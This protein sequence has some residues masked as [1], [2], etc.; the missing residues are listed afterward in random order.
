MQNVLLIKGES[1]Y[2]A[3]RN[4]VDEIEV[5]FRLAGYNTHVI[6]A[7]EQ[8]WMFQ[9]E[10]LTSGLRVDFLFVCNAVLPNLLPNAY[11]L[12]YL[13]DHPVLHKERLS[14][15]NE[16]AC[17]FVCDRRHVAYVQQYYPNIKHVAYIPLS[18]QASGTYIPYACRSK[19]LVFTGGYR[20]PEQMYEHIF[21]CEE[22]LHA[23]AKDTV[24]ELIK[25]PEKDL[26]KGLRDS[27]SHKGKELS[28][29]EFHETMFQFMR[30]DAYVRSYYRDQ[31]I[32]SLVK[33]GVQVHVF[34]NGWEKFEG[35]GKENLILE[36]GDDYIARKA[37][38]D[39]KISL[40]IMPWFKDGFQE[41]IASAM[42]SATVAL[43][44]ESDYICKH[45]ADG[46]ELALYSLEHLDTLPEKV[47]WL[48][49]HPAEA[50]QIAN[51][52]KERAK[53][54][55]TWQHRTF[56]MIRYAE[57]CFGLQTPPEG[58]HGE[59]LPISYRTLHERSM[60]SDAIRSMNELIEMISQVRSH[61]KTDFA[62][63]DYFNT[64]FLFAFV[65][66][67]ANCPEVN[68]SEV[69]QNCIRS[70]SKE[71]ADAGA[72]LL[73]IECMHMLA[74]FLSMENHELAKEKSLLQSKLTKAEKIT[75]RFV[76]EALTEK[77]K[78][79]CQDLTDTTCIQK[80]LQNL[81]VN[82]YENGILDYACEKFQNGLYEEALEAFVLSYMKGYQREWVLSNIYS[83][84][85]NCNE[86]EFRTA[87]EKQCGEELL[88]YE[89][90]IL[91][92]IPYTNAKYYI[93][94]KELKIFRGIF[95]LEALQS[96]Q[97]DLALSQMEF[98]AL[99]LSMEWNWNEE[100]TILRS[101]KERKIYVVCQDLKRCASFL[102]IPEL[103]DYMKNIKIFSGF[104]EFKNYFHQNISEY[105]PRMIYG[106]ESEAKQLEELIK[107][108]HEFRLTPEGR[109]TDNVLLTIGIP[110]YNRGHLLLKR[111]ERLLA[112]PYDAEIEI[113]ISKNGTEL[114]QKEYE[115]AERIPDARIHYVPYEQTP[116][117]PPAL[118]W[119]RTVEI[120]HGRYVLFVSDEDDVILDAL[121]HYFKLLTE[122]PQLSQVRGKTM[123]QYAGLEKGYGKKGADA[124]QLMFLSQNYLSGLIVRKKDFLDADLKRLEEYNHN[125]FYNVY[126]HAC[127]CAL[128]STRGDAMEETVTLIAEG[129]SF[130]KTETEEYKK[131]G[132]TGVENTF[133]GNSILQ[134]YAT[135]EARLDQF[136]G[137]VAFL[138]TLTAEYEELA[139]LGLTLAVRK[140]AYLLELAR[141]FQYDCGNYESMVDRF[142]WLC[143]DAVDEF[144]LTQNQ[145]RHIL[146]EITLCGLH[147]LE[148]PKKLNNEIAEILHDKAI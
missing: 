18:G 117:L 79:N 126:P 17:V 121:E 2:N 142:L 93:F 77:V 83:C 46:K 147:E 50:E 138:H 64:K 116:A 65:K 23:L 101:G 125:A 124:F 3:L 74:V 136:R 91:D 82:H 28:E 70:L 34:G 105:L 37:V 100:K 127:W 95:S 38:A 42:L 90:C 140:T 4:Y 106:R 89:A 97:P 92:F 59:I 132:C 62:D 33:N 20:K 128:L 99:A 76:W 21:S 114:Y 130:L 69:I 104:K 25:H 40:N 98:S 81:D 61:G 26:E 32:R 43:T 57:Q 8:S 129:E 35:T 141:E 80:N 72:E 29:Q 108:E 87:F 56:E 24:T 86:N 78:S 146:E 75:N 53:R 7:T 84:Y 54:E 68:F 11:Y 115:Q 88:T 148:L 139:V 71:Q 120:S 112:M 137:M 110:T 60:L 27:L 111:L 9:Y 63:I 48:L 131:L 51:T 144:A 44:D 52:G 135:Y 49:E 14:E 31:V 16:Q 19:S 143:M 39:A 122:H 6:D 145:R 30:I 13:T 58:V 134:W 73:I 103:A 113:A 55:L 119:H 1:Q 5:G 102:K 109:S 118:N 107:R 123:V 45:F 66:F 10:E 85:L 67:H 36:Q 22:G 15:L 133:V 47:R 94:D 12:T 96:T 41:R